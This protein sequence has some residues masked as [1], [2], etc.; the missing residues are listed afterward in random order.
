MRIVLVFAI[1]FLIMLNMFFIVMKWW[2]F[3][4]VFEWYIIDLAMRFVLYD[5]ESSVGGVSIT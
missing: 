5:K 1:R 2:V 3:Y 4:N